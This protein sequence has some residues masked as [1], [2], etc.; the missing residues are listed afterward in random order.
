[1][2]QLSHLYRTTG[3]TIDL[4]RQTFVGKG[5]SLLFNMLCRFSSKEQCLLISCSQ[6]PSAVILEP[7]KIKSVMVS[8]VSPSICHEVMGPDAMIL[9]FWM[10]NFKPAFSL[11][12]FTFI[13][14]LFS[15]SLLVCVCTYVYV[16]VC[17]VS[18][19]LN[20]WAHP[21]WN[22]VLKGKKEESFLSET[23]KR[24]SIFLKS[25]IAKYNIC[26]FIM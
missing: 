5:M 17:M 3:K 13:K 14:R 8:I 6:S 16:H 25:Q 2:V 18:V 11:F 19:G 15:S 1:M 9:V 20:H 21:H 4:T 23:F 24:W 22:D 26:L 10:L 7:K 12:S